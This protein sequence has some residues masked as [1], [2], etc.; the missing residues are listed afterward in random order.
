MQPNQP[1]GKVSSQGDF[2]WHGHKETDET[3]VVLEGD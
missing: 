2:I 3:F 1:T